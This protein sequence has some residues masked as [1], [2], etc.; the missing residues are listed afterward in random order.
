MNRTS[1][2]RRL[3]LGVGLCSL[4][5]ITAMTALLSLPLSASAQAWPS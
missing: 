3:V 4:A 1:I 5:G 2:N